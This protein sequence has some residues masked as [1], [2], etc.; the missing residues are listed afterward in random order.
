MR[1]AFL[2][3]VLLHGLIHLMGFTKAFGYGNLAEFSKDISRPIGLLWLLVGLLFIVSSILYWKKMVA[4]SLL[5]IIA[6][7]LSQILIFIFWS[8]AKFVT[9]VNAIIL[10]VGISAYGLYRFN[11]MVFQET[12][13]LVRDIGPGGISVV[14]K[15]DI[16]QLP[17]R[18]QEW[19]QSSG[20]MGTERLVS[21]HLRQKGKMKIKPEGKWMPFTAEQYFDVSKPAFIWSTEVDFLPLIKMVGRDKFID[22]K[23]EMLIKLANVIPVVNEGD[24][25][26]INSG[27]MV[28]YLAEMVW[29]PSAALNHYVHWETMDANSVKATFTLNGKSV[30]GI[31]EFSENGE[32]QS[33]EAERYYG[34]GKD[35]SLETWLIK[36]EEY[37]NFIGFKI[38]NKCSVTWK[39]KEGDF[40][41][42][43][44]EITDWT[45]NNLELTKN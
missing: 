6:M 7:V 35:A 31:F 15:E 21:V 24:N 37:K 29:F 12:Q 3:M 18:V 19:M 10:V 45:F 20:V 40:N 43:N 9:I 28:R 30:F 26:K 11:K 22:G 1:I 39:L 16:R 42:L 25:E 36:V 44:L 5:V 8:D 34:G 33:F 17:E 32:M 38:P 2:V 13:D 4:W 27:A 14:T 23:G 41:W